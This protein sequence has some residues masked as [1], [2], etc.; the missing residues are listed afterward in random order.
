MIMTDF[1]KGLGMLYVENIHVYFIKELGMF[2]KK[3]ILFL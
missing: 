2:Y 3:K 1:I